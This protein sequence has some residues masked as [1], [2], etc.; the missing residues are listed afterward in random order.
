MGGCASSPAGPSKAP[1]VYAVPYPEDGKKLRTDASL[2]Q[3]YELG[4]QIGEGGFSRVRLATHRATGQAFACKIIPLPRPGKAVNENLSDRAAIMK[5]I[6]ALLDLDHPRVIELREYFVQQNRVHLIMELL[7]GGELLDAVLEQGHYSEADARTIFRQLMEALQYLHS[8]GVVH[9]DLKLDNLLLVEPGDI[10]SIKLADF[11]FAKKL[12][13]GLDGM[14]TVCG[15]PGYIAPEVILGIMKPSGDP[16]PSSVDHRY[17]ESCDLWSAGV[18]L[19]MLLAGVPPFHDK[20][21]PRLLRSIMAGK[22]SL[23]DPVWEE[24]SGEAKDLVSKLLVVDPA[25]RL[26]CQQ[27]MEHPWM[28]RPAEAGREQQLTR[29]TARIQDAI[30]KRDSSSSMR[31]TLKKRIS[32][33]ISA[34]ASPST[35]ALKAAALAA[36]A[37][38]LPASPQGG[39]PIATSVNGAAHHPMPPAQLP[40]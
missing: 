19:Y 25:S 8:K 17:N 27:V 32:D 2:E 20:S 35:N 33:A 28:T 22:Y 36:V 18:I 14:K 26:T 38:S 24:I 21:E 13:G 12:H 34:S 37:G 6:D 4:A 9:R 11:G 30:T 39:S 40:S 10:R 5:E 7:R 23:D 29:T 31:G 1:N 16:Q 3:E 15:T